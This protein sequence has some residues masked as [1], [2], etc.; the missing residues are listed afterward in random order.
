MT[1]L[2]VD[3][4]NGLIEIEGELEFVERIYDEMRPFL[5]GRLEI[6][7]SAKPVKN[8]SGRN[9]DNPSKEQKSPRRRKSAGPSCASRIKELQDDGF[10]ALP[11]V[12]GE[13]KEKL[14]EKGA[15]YENKH[16]AAALTQLTQSSV[17]RRFKEEK[18]WHYQNP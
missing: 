18:T 3:L 13:V 17:L 16:V 1:R 14:S 8:G 11:R 4:Q 6:S 15:T 10:F 9:K 7:P 12:V 5:L 2:S